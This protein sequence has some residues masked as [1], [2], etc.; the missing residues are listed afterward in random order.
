M[1]APPAYDPRPK[2][3]GKLIQR[4]I[5]PAGGYL[6]KA[7][8]K[9]A[10]AGARGAWHRSSGSSLIGLEHPTPETSSKLNTRLLVRSISV[11]SRVRLIRKSLPIGRLLDRDALGCGAV[12][13]LRTAQQSKPVGE[14][15]TG[16]L[17][18]EIEFL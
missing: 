4:A 9:P 16:S 18:C 10:R 14:R 17:M 6:E 3:W 7:D 12:G 15:D 11:R 5:R 2:G 13:N 8:T 1:P